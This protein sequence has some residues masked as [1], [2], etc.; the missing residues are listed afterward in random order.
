MRCVIIVLLFVAVMFNNCDARGIRSKH[1]VR[2][3]NKAIYNV[4][5]KEAYNLTNNTAMYNCLK[6]NSTQNCKHIENF[7][8]YADVKN[9]CVDRNNGEIGTGL[10]I[11][12]IGWLMLSLIC[13]QV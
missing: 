7:T 11:A 8:D 2:N 5:N 10:F 9:I 3:I 4:C 13:R 6:V 1:L 12:I